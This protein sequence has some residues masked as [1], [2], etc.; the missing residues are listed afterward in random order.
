MIRQLSILTLVTVLVSDVQSGHAQPRP[1]PPTSQAVLDEASRLN[2]LVEKL[3]SEGKFGEAVPIAERALALREKV[4]GPMHP[5]VAES[6]NDLAVLYLAQGAHAK[7]EPLLVRALDIREQ[8]LGPMHPDVAN[9]L[10][11]LALLYQAQGAYARA[12]PLLVRA[13]DIREQALG[14]MH[15]DVAGS[16]NNL[17][18][19]YQAQGAYAKAEPLLVRALD[20]REQALGPMHPDVAESLNNLASLYWAQGAYAKA[21]PL[22]VCALDIWQK[23]LG[24]MHPDVA[25]SLNN[26]ASLYR[27][28]GAYA[29]AEPLLVRALDIRE[30]AL[31]PMHPDVAQSLNSSARLYRAQGAYAK[32]EPLLV[33]ALDIREQ[34]LGPMHPDVAESLNNLAVFYQFQG[35]YAKAEPL[36]VR[37]LDIDEKALG[38]MHPLVA[39]SLNNLALLYRDQGAYAKAEPLYVR[40]LAIYEKA[41][42]PMHPLVAL[43]LNNLAVNYRD[44]GAYA[45]AEPLLVRAL[46]I[47]EKA[48]GPMHTDV[49]HSLHH[50]ALLYRDQGAYAKAEPLLVRGL[51]IYE[52]ALGPM[53]PDVAQILN[54]L[55]LLYQDQGAYA[56]AEPLYA[57]ALDIREEALGPMHPL[58]GTSLINLARL[59][60][61]Q[62]AYAQAEPRLSRAADIRESQL[63]SSLAPLPESRTRAMMALVQGETENLVSFHVDASPSSPRARELALTTVL[64]RK[65]RVLDS[66]TEAQRTLR[67]HLTPAL[68]DQLDQLAQARSELTAQ[69]Y[70][71]G[72]QRGFT[73]R[74]AVIATVRT[75]IDD[76]EAGLSVASSEFRAQNE[77]VSLANVQAALPPGAMLVEFVR[78]HRF[79]ARA[80]PSEQEERYVAYLVTS[81]GPPRWVPLGE[82]ALIDAAVDAV[83]ATLQA[84]VRAETTR[85]ALQHLDALVV[86]P[87]RDQLAEVSHLILAPDGKLNLV[88]FE[89]LIDAQ[90]HY[91]LERYLVSYLSSGR[92]LLRLAAHRGPRSPAVIVAGPDYGPLPSHPAPG[93][94]AFLPLPDARAEAADLGRY[95]PTPPVTDKQATK[96]ALAALLGPTMLH[97]ATHGFY[98]RD[99]G[100]TPAL[101]SRGPSAPRPTAFAPPA[102]R[103]MRVE[104]DG[105]MSSLSSPPSS[106]DPAEG[107]DRAGLAMAGANQGAQG[108]VT[109]REI[110]GFDWWGTQL[111]V[112]SACE[113]GVGAVPSGD[114]VYG[115]RRAL[116]LAGAESQVVSLW[117]VSDAST[118]ALMRDYYGEL[119]RG[120][121][122]A[123]ALRRAQL[124]L[125]HQPRYAH[126]YYWAA[127]IPAGDWRPLDKN[128][129][130]PQGPRP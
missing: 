127:F 61:A 21:E 54:N 126:P 102:P 45:K 50:L 111:V 57:R 40:A 98:A 91:E 3:Y 60:Q 7:A 55:A 58:V 74:A 130:P 128:T 62:G 30:Q 23:A 92:D 81:Q 6:L 11:N 64:R 32:A 48:L 108:I 68:R 31:G 53:H 95:F 49:A 90:G 44:Q 51:D 125:L 75:R 82:A 59:Y 121:G 113:T 41:L 47:R 28:Q 2:K 34:A 118:R 93:T 116:V 73:Q 101:G 36:L 78:Y 13:L 20:I 97:V 110:A 119:A 107:L 87:L 100:T 83:L 120:T 42:G 80:Q 88:P 86:T 89:A 9:S 37:T 46:D 25:Q 99:P 22:L 123:E 14:P 84:P 77:P 1:S 103:G 94:A 67:D 114:G 76:L 18:A 112:L 56:K 72:E 63:R 27:A 33:R 5:G 71:A 4:L 38:P 19:L 66:L 8:A 52:K 117:S 29:K 24:P 12:E 65:G 17:A 26:L 96:E 16:L 124:H 79:D 10:N 70:A 69:L 43:S 35:A 109:A 106:S 115:M 85:T 122:R 104:I 39:N 129:R 105:D 15:P